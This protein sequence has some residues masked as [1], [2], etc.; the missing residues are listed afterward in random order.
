MWEMLL[1]Q[2][3]YSGRYFLNAVLNLYK[4]CLNLY[5]SLYLMLFRLHENVNHRLKQFKLY[6]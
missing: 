4:G 6:C 3:G 5:F 1:I 2:F